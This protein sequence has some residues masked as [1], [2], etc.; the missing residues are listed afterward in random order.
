MGNVVYGTQGG[1]VYANSPT[2][3]SLNTSTVGPVTRP[4]NF[5]ETV[6]RSTSEAIALE[7]GNQ[8]LG[9]LIGVGVKGAAATSSAVSNFFVSQGISVAE[10]TSAR[11]AS[12]FGRE[13]D[14]FTAAAE[15]M[16]AARDA[17]WKTADGRIW[18]PPGSGEV[19]GTE[20]KTT[21]AVGTR[22]D[23]YGGT[24][25]NSTFLAPVNTPLEQRAMSPTT[26]TALRDEYIVL[27]PLPVEQS[28]TMPWFGQSGMGQQFNTGQ[29]GLT[30]KNGKP[31]T[32][33]NLVESG[34][35]EKVIQ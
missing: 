4:D 2:S 32:I 9:A 22:V 26:N 20:F 30:L 18:W 21:L 14:A 11:I 8:A 27:K 29:G 5:Q 16:V 25:S 23:R 15:R 17:G 24:G 13:G 1:L 3:T 7:I 31:A 6:A 33:E 35:L 19:P 28:N 10:E 34:Y 12:N